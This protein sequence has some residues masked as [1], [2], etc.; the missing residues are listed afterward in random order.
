MDR[1][2]G[3]VLSGMY[4]FQEDL[5]LAASTFFRNF[6]NLFCFIHQKGGGVV[7]VF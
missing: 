2:S 1:L 5:S 3:V 4:C 7:N 6:E